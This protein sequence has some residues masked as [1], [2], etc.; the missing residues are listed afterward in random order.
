[1]TKNQNFRIDLWR[2]DSGKEVPL[3]TTLPFEKA[4]R[5]MAVCEYDLEEFSKH[6]YLHNGT[7]IKIID[8]DRQSDRSNYIPTKAT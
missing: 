5:L 6:I 7:Q 3:F 1:M 8:F 2:K 4:K